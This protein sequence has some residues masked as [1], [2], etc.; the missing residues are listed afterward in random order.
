MNYQKIY[1][2]IIE[3]RKINVATGYTEEHHIVPRCLGGSN[4][5][6]NLVKLTAKE[7]FICHL[8]LTKMYT[9][10]SLEYYK[11]CH[12]FLMML[13]SS[14]GNQQRYITAK[15]YEKLKI[16]FSKR[17]SDIG[18]GKQNSQYGTKWIHNPTLEEN[19]KILKSDILDIGWEP[20]RV[21]DWEKYKSDK[22]KKENKLIEKINKKQKKSEKINKHLEKKN[23]LDSIDWE[24]LY[25]IYTMYG[26]EIASHL[27]GYY[28]SRESMIMQFKRRVKDYQPSQKMKK[29]WNKNYIIGV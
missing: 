23:E 20:G 2:S 19:K 26:Y 24:F 14:S 1:Y 16:D 21:C 27:T 8:L 3:K 7:H 18:S 25:K 28:K 13:R 10:E 5:K 11:M 6:L 22:I 17:M 4:D 15:R 9:K 12:A 29:I